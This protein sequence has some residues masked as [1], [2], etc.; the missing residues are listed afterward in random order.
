MVQV[1]W[2]VR[3]GP[4]KGPKGPMKKHPMQPLIVARSYGKVNIFFWRI[5]RDFSSS[6]SMYSGERQIANVRF[7][8]GSTT[9]R[10]AS[11]VSSARHCE[12]HPG[13]SSAMSRRRLLSLRRRPQSRRA[14]PSSR[15][16]EEELAWI[17]AYAGMTLKSNGHGQL[18]RYDNR[19]AGTAEMPSWSASSWRT[20]PPDL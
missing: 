12:I 8:A 18:R 2:G 5:Y 20:W 10:G 17:P 3:R 14:A 13:F 9:I 6:L 7:N 4:A 15:V 16:Y 11:N 19:Q 1:Y